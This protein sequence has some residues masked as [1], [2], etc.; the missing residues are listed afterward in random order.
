MKGLQYRCLD[1]VSRS[2][3]E[4]NGRIIETAAGLPDHLRSII[5]TFL[6]RRGQVNDEI[7]VHLGSDA[8]HELDLRDCSDLTD[9]VCEAIGRNCRGLRALNLQLTGGPRSFTS[10][11]LCNLITFGSTKLRT[12][13]MTRCLLCDDDVLKA[14]A[15][16]CQILKHL[17]IAGCTRVTD[18]GLFGLA[19]S[20][21]PLV[22]LDLSRTSITDAGCIALA[23]KKRKRH[24]INEIHL[25]DCCDVSDEGVSA[26][27]RALPAL[28]TLLLDGCP[29]VTA[30]SRELLTPQSGGHLQ[31]TI[32]W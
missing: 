22:G 28:R 27:I 31:W 29:K 7:V 12:L 21:A 1:V 10:I 11:S 19:R 30:A 25:S 26:L 24:F 16:N 14:I 8:L 15:E 13:R 6:A 18:E 4:G 17:D 5:L 20:P 23:T 2:L 3:A 32:E 9:S